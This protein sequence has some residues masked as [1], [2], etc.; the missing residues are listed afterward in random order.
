V[1]AAVAAVASSSS[2]AAG[3]GAVRGET[4]ARVAACGPLS[5]RECGADDGDHADFVEALH[6]LANAH[7]DGDAGRGKKGSKSSQSSQR[8]SSSS[9]GGGQAEAEGEGSTA[10]GERLGQLTIS[11][12]KVAKVTS[13]RAYSVAIM[14]VRGTTVVAV[15][16]KVGNLGLW[17]Y[18]DQVHFSMMPLFC[19]SFCIFG[20]V[21]W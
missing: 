21:K 20:G 3:L 5:L 16:D 12:E 10:Y 6:A 8:Q 15:G 9:S 7:D 13:D 11:D 1:A 17:N 18:S 19:Y 2:S 14:P 4:S